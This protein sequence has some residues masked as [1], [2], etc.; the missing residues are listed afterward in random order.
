[1]SDWMC[2]LLIT[3]VWCDYQGKSLTS[4]HGRAAAG[5]SPDP[6]SWLV[7]TAS[8]RAKNPTSV[9]C[10]RG[11]SPAQT[12]W[13]CTWR[14]TTEAHTYICLS[15][16]YIQMYTTYNY[17]IWRQAV[18]I[19]RNIVL[20]LSITITSNTNQKQIDWY[21]QFKKCPSVAWSR[22]TDIMAWWLQIPTPGDLVVF[23]QYGLTSFD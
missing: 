20:I 22:S 14:D 17:W 4:V 8:T 11:P 10:V 19:S 16:T 2:F 9:C 13:L 6:M 15:N 5:N 1:M 7:T 12:T 21:P 3:V 23:W 18:V